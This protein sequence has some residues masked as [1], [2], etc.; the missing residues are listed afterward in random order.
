MTA[1]AGGT[2]GWSSTSKGNVVETAAVL[3]GTQMN[4]AGGA[5]PWG[6]WIACEET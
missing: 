2:S 3:A 5:T 6:S 1:R 4:C